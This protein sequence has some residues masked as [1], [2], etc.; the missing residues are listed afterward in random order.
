VPQP[1]FDSRGPGTAGAHWDDAT[2]NTEL[3]GYIN[4]SDMSVADMILASLARESASYRSRLAPLMPPS[5]PATP[6]A[7]ASIVASDCE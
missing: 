2:F 6:S 3:T 5:T 7:T 4:P 1:R